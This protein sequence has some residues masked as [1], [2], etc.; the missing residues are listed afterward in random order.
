MLFLYGF[1]FETP[2]QHLRNLQHG[3]DD[4]DSAAVLIEAE[5]AN[6]AREWG[7]Q[8][9][10]AFLK[11]LHEDAGVSWAAGRYADW[12]DE[13][14]DAERRNGLATVATGVMPDLSTISSHRAP[15]P[16]RAS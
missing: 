8:I 7:R 10:E 5:S 11:W 3:W 9:A 2:A 6:E 15:V 4:E 1:G 16:H 12:V 14:A 13:N